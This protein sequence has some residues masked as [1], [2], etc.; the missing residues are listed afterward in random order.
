MSNMKKLVRKTSRAESIDG[1]TLDGA[2]ETLSRFRE[3]F[4][5]NAVIEMDYD[6]TY[7]CVTIDVEESDEEY[8]KRVAYQGTLEQNAKNKRL[9]Q[10]QELHKEFGTNEVYLKGNTQ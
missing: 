1:D 9:A 3:E 10:Y 2:I 5:G 7:F 6:S 8:A 4:T